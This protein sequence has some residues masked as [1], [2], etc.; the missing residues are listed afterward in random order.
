MDQ[1]HTRV[2][3]C[4]WGNSDALDTELTKYN[5]QIDDMT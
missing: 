5:V 4:K 2:W 1:G 3:V